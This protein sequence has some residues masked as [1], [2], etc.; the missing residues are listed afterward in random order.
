[1]KKTEEILHEAEKAAKSFV[2]PF[3]LGFIK[4]LLLNMVGVLKSFN[5]RLNALE[6][7]AQDER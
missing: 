1:M 6:Q 5:E 3:G 4:P 2:A 7:G